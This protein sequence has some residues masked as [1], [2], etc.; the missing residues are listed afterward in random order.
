MRIIYVLSCMDG[1]ESNLA[2]TT[3]EAAEAEKQRM[4]DAEITSETD[5]MKNG[6]ADEFMLAHPFFIAEYMRD[7]IHIS[8][9]EL[10]ES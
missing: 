2:F 3:K 5:L 7:G 6:Q 1:L 9:M 8:E 4:I 10:I